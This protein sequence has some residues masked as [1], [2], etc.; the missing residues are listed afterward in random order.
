MNPPW[1]ELLMGWPMGWTCVDPMSALQFKSWGDGFGTNPGRPEELPAL[2]EATGT[3]EIRGQAGRP[4]SIH[5]TEVLF[6]DLCQQPQASEALGHLSPESQEVQE[7]CLRSLRLPEGTSSPS[8]GP[9]SRE[10]RPNQSPDVVQALPRFLAH[11]GPQAWQDGSWENAIPRVA[12]NVA[13]R[14]DRLK[15]IGNGQVPAVACLAWKTLM[16]RLTEN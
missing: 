11:Y 8:C 1:V 15:A 9:E 2:W 5:Q 7:G 10:Q 12:Q 3:E 16:R 6:V 14:V 13:R 4:D